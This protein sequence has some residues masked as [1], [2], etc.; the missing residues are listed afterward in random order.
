[1]PDDGFLMP[2]KLSP[3]ALNYY[4][5]G[6]PQHDRIQPIQLG[7]SRMDMA[8]G[9]IED[10]R[11]HIVRAFTA[12]LM[13]MK[14]DTNREMTATEVLQRQ[15]DRLRLIAPMVGRM[16]TEALGPVISRVYN[17]LDRRG[18]I[19]EPPEQLNEEPLRIEYTS[20]VVQAQKTARLSSFSRMIDSVGPLMEMK[21]AIMDN[22][23][24]DGFFRFVHNLLDLPPETMNDGQT[25][26]AIREDR[27]EQ[28]RAAEQAALLKDA[29]PGMRAMRD[30]GQ[31]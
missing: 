29:G 8:T 6:L 20:P 23:N 18:L 19:P 1:M 30:A 22:F 11:S 21:P 16:Q 13:Q 15:E 12:D 27:E 26:G 17:I 5:A 28:E 25:V 10:R 3:S 24:E 4:R 14:D 9:L 31:S 7:E 2:V